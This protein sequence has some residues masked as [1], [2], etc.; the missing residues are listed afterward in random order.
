MATGK[1]WLSA[2]NA[3]TYVYILAPVIVVLLIAFSGTSSLAFPPASYSLRWFTHF[4]HQPELM[5]AL[6]MSFTLAILASLLSLV[7][8][9]AA[10]FGIVRGNLPGRTLVLNGLMLPLMVPALAIGVSFLQ[11]YTLFGVPS[12]P[13]LLLGH[14]V[15][16]LPYVVRTLV[17]GLENFDVSLENAAVSLG[18][19]R[20]QAVLRVTLPMLGNSILA[21]ALFS[22][23]MSFENLPIALFLSG[24][25][26]VTLPMQIYSYITWVFDPTV[27]AASAIQVVIVVALAVVIE[28]MVGLNR[29]ISLR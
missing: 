14:V 22:F 8:G 19:T 1:H 4:A 3:A 12:F 10:A 27:A 28:R 21:A 5:H 17:A 23:I 29:L 7:I 25:S 15:I 18:A 20:T 11:F 13:S 24:P 16:T 2:V 26:T 9:G 6:G